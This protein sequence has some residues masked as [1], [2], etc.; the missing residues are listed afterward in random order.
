MEESIVTRR[1]SFRV[2]PEVEFAKSDSFKDRE[3]DGRVESTAKEVDR[4]L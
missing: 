1:E 4:E 3:R 2:M